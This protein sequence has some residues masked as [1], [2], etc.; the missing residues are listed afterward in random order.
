MAIMRKNW[1]TCGHMGRSFQCIRSHFNRRDSKQRGQIDQ[2]WSCSRRYLEEVHDYVRERVG[3]KWGGGK[4]RRWC[5]TNYRWLLPCCLGLQYSEELKR[6]KSF[7]SPSWT[8]T[9][10]VPQ[11]HSPR[12]QS[13]ERPQTSFVDPSR[14]AILNRNRIS[15]FSP[16]LK[17][18]MS[19]AR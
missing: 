13:R 2:S 6:W 7:L 12:H 19:I 8:S 17:Y 4:V 10:R 18:H 15:S 3:E 11:V 16:P 5:G 1:P 9:R 14:H